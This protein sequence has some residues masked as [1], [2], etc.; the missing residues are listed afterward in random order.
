VL[1]NVAIV[2]EVLGLILMRTSGH[3]WVGLW[4]LS[5]LLLTGAILLLVRDWRIFS[6][7]DEGDR[8]LKFL[9]AGYVW[10]M[11]SLAMLVA[12]PLYQQG[13]LALLAPESAAAR[14]GFS[15]AY[16][17]AIRH[18]ITVGFVSLMIV[19]VAAKVV[20]TLNGVPWQRLSPLW[21]PFVLINLGCTLRVLG[22]TATDFVPGAFP[23]AGVSGLLEVTGLAL[24]GGHLW[25]I[26]SG[27]A[28]LRDAKAIE[29]PVLHPEN[30]IEGRHTVGAVLEARP[31]LLEV[32]VDHG[33]TTLANP[34]L[35]R[36]IAR[37]VTIETACRRMGVHL[38]DFLNALN[39]ETEKAPHVCCGDPACESK[40][41]PVERTN[42]SKL[43][44]GALK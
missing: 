32:F 11:I 38:D 25:L 27:R 29:A 15:H 33:F 3:A 35:R 43:A 8:S 31:E 42:H 9:R 19:G 4:Y 24:W 14:M 17:G 44:T 12:L 16:Y 2:G 36:S 34:A 5:A 26:M 18:A 22:Q 7:T 30:L 37:L 23:V 21:G 13:L 28:R 41:D 10:L 20:P 40:T 1:L 6:R 39:G